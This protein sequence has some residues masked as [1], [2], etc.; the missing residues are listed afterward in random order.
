MSILIETELYSLILAP[1]LSSP[2]M[3]RQECERTAARALACELIGEKCEIGHYPDGAPYLSGHE[4]IAISVSHSSTTCAFGLASSPR[5]LG[6]DIEAPRPQLER[7][8]SRFLTTEETA[9]FDAITSATGKME[10]LLK[11]WTAKEAVYKAA[12]TPG[13][14]LKEIHLD[15]GLTRAETQGVRYGL[16]YHGT[17]DGQ[18]ICVACGEVS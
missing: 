5:P 8:R 18:I 13:L 7:V 14:G 10:F 17:D 4:E 6:I 2:S 11:C 15:K 12:R 16:S 9:E 1:I 3:T